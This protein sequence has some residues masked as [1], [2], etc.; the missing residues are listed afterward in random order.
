MIA[1]LAL[2]HFITQLFVLQKPTLIFSE[3]FFF[4]ALCS[5]LQLKKVDKLNY[6]TYP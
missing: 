2:H 3:K 4:G 1:A 6:P 5:R